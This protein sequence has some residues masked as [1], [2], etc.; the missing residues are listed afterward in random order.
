MNKWFSTAF[1]LTTQVYLEMEEV[2]R[3]NKLRK[4]ID[5]NRL[6]RDGKGMKPK[7][8]HVWTQHLG[9]KGHRLTGLW[10]LVMLG[11]KGTR[12]IL[13]KF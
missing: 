12:S 2:R 3:E 5:D 6:T 8:S 13:N 9:L 4:M 7:E 11:I 10:L 1:A